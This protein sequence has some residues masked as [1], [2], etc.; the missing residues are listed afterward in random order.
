MGML[1]S[2]RRPRKLEAG[3]SASTPCPICG[4]PL[5]TDA[6]RGAHHECDCGSEQHSLQVQSRHSFK[7]TT[8]DWRRVGREVSGECVHCRQIL[9]VP[10]DIWTDEDERLARQLELPEWM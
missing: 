10:V 8:R 9:R 4:D 1:P 5:G 6:Q 3:A 2:K 7:W